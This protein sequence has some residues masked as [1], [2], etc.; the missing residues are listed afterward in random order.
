[1]V[2][3]LFNTNGGDANLQLQ[4]VDFHLI[5]RQ[6]GLF[7]LILMMRMFKK[8][9]IVPRVTD[10][11]DHQNNNIYGICPGSRSPTAPRYP[12]EFE[13]NNIETDDV[14]WSTIESIAYYIAS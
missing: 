9:E 4:N 3:R 5:K 1:M 12:S 8:T 2:S 7:L 14:D 11:S 10:D 13:F 6:S